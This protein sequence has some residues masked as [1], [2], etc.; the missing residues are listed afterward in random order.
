M[1]APVARAHV[2]LAPP[3]GAQQLASIYYAR[4]AL[5]FAPLVLSIFV[6]SLG[7]RR[8][9]R[10]S[11]YMATVCA[12]YA[13]YYF[14]TPA[15]ETYLPPIAFGWLPNIMAILAVVFVMAL[16]AGA[17]IPGPPNPKT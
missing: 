3:N 2:R 14:V 6:L 7:G 17:Q 10:A 16:P 11:I 4:W 13:G 8:R 9:L 15:L 1:L 12:V 5:A